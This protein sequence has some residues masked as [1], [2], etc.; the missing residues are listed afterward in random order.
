MTA[1]L[2]PS[3]FPPEL[4]GLAAKVLGGERLDSADATL[5][6]ETPHLLHLGRLADHVRRKLHGDVAFYNVNRHINPT[7]V[8]VYTYD[9]KFCG[10]AALKG[11]DHAWEMSHEEV[12]EHAAQA[13]R[14]RGD[15]VP[16]RRRSSPRPLARLV[17]GD[18]ARA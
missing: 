12:Y 16:H 8:C 10:F 11:E 13:G 17:P 9:C 1:A 6:Y 18:A 2:D 3:K 15:R 4:Q 14:R 5:C 7:N